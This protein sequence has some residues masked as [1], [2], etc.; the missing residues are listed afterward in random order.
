MFGSSFMNNFW[1]NENNINANTKR[2]GKVKSIIKNNILLIIF[3]IIIKFL[4]RK[5]NCYKIIF[6]NEFNI[7]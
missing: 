6:I 2:R 5:L 7:L 3:A 4:L 1:F